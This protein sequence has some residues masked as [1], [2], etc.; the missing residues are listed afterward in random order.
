MQTGLILVVCLFFV[1]FS[2]TFSQIIY[3]YFSQKTF[4]DHFV[5][6][7]IRTR[8]LGTNTSGVCVTYYF[9]IYISTDP[10]IFQQIMQVSPKQ[11]RKLTVFPK[12]DFSRFCCEICWFGSLNELFH[13]KNLSV[14]ISSRSPYFFR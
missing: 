6:V 5:N 4:R 3:G 11:F 12:V 8:L 13:A 9:D 10:T 1:L 14:A 2:N 7:S